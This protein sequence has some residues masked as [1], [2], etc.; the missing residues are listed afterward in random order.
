MLPGFSYRYTGKQWILHLNP[1]LSYVIQH[2]EN[3][4]QPEKFIFL[5][6]EWWHIA[7]Q[8]Q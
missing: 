6:T 4:I 8:T 3:T 1:L 7:T 5:A 2:Y